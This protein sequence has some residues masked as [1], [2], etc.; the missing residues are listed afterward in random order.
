MQAFLFIFCSK[1]C[2]LLLFNS[3]FSAILC[4]FLINIMFTF[5]QAPSVGMSFFLIYIHHFFTR[6][7][8]ESFL[9]KPFRYFYL[10]ISLAAF[11]Q[12][13]FWHAKC[14]N[15]SKPPIFLYF[16]NIIFIF[17]LAFYFLFFYTLIKFFRRI[18][19]FL[20]LLNRFRK[21]GCKSFTNRNNINY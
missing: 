3:M 1:I 13:T 12:K 21:L 14:V 9:R 18:F 11:N 8:V 20:R 6:M 7:L 5:S 4:N 16:F 15:P 17:S 2:F 19:F 10:L